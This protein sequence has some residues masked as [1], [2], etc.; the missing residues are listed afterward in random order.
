[1][2]K[3]KGELPQYAHYHYTSIGCGWSGFKP[4]I[5]SHCSRGDRCQVVDLKLTN[6]CFDDVEPSA[7]IPLRAGFQFSVADIGGKKTFNDPANRSLIRRRPF[8]AV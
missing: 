6:L 5:I 7:I 1:L 3:F 2:T 4:D 8:P